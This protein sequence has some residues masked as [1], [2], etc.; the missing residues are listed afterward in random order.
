MTYLQYIKGDINN[1]LSLFIISLIIY[2]THFKK[3]H[4]I[5]SLSVW[6]QQLRKENKKSSKAFLVKLLILIDVLVASLISCHYRK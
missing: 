1:N 2:M 3:Y 5:V 6:Y 4:G